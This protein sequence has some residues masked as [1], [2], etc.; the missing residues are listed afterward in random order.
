[1]STE[2]QP[3]SAK[4]PPQR[5][6]LQNPSAITAVGETA[7]PEQ[8]SM[9]VDAPALAPPPTFAATGPA[10]PG[11][12]APPTFGVA[13]MV[14]LPNVGDPHWIF[15]GDKW[16]ILH[17]HGCLTCDSYMR[18]LRDDHPS[19][20]RAADSHVRAQRQLFEN[21]VDRG[22]GYADETIE[23][24]R[25]DANRAY[26]K[27]EDKLQASGKELEQARKTEKRLRTE[28]DQEREKNTAL[29]TQLEELQRKLQN[30]VTVHDELKAKDAARR[31]PVDY[32][33]EDEDDDTAAWKE[34]AVQSARLASKGSAPP[35]KKRKRGAPASNA[36]ASSSA[37]P[38]P[39]PPADMHPPP[40]TSSGRQAATGSSRRGPPVT[41]WAT[42]SP[43]SNA[44]AKDLIEAV[45]ADLSAWSRIKTLM[46]LI[47]TKRAGE[48]THW[49]R[50][51]VTHWPEVKQRKPTGAGGEG[52]STQPAATATPAASSSSAAAPPAAPTTTTKGKGKAKA[53]AP[54]PEPMDASGP[55]TKTKGKGKAKARAPT[56]PEP[57]D[58][59]GD[60]ETAEPVQEHG[61]AGAG[62]PTV[63]NTTSEWVRHV[64][65]HPD[66]RPLGVALH[67]RPLELAGSPVIPALEQHLA[68]RRAGP[69][70]RGEFNR[71]Q[72]GIFV[73][74]A[75]E[76]FSVRGMYEAVLSTTDYKFSQTNI[77]PV[78]IP[79]E[80]DVRNL[81]YTTIALHFA[82]CGYRPRGA[83]LPIMENYAVARRN[84]QLSRP[85][86]SELDWPTEP[87]VRS[88]VAEYRVQRPSNQGMYLNVHSNR[89]LDRRPPLVPTTGGPAPSSSS[90]PRAQ[91]ST[92]AVTA[93]GPVSNDDDHPG[94]NG[95]TSAATASGEPVAAVDND[96]TMLDPHA[97]PL[98]GEGEEL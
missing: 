24:I 43:R 30:L 7:H 20:E 23:N 11:E 28:R 64:Y 14:R 4:Q 51:V 61:S 60:T 42:F 57:M 26:G 21:G 58:V 69:V 91:S 56:S 74:L 3:T 52:E 73:R 65:A 25:A 6:S 97:V 41:G 90:A 18:H 66:Q 34:A 37:V 79:Y 35:A 48:R 15:D 77:H 33:D 19:W 31:G 92:A 63:F 93:S 67:E 40:P 47:G 96:A 12:S 9:A 2:Q 16:V 44:D 55:A 1:M 27:L 98:P 8:E 39:A 46:T 45:K 62:A 38:L 88:L 53:H 13:P 83:T 72:R 80:G 78:P 87:T 36:V 89:T 70:G 68:V 81:T 5:P 54:S 76:M 95:S 59:S 17:S 82:R 29:S 32:S 10:L 49:E 84:E 94:D 86:N 22:L 85:V 71:Q 75:E 50:L